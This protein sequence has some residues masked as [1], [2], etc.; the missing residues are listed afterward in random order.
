MFELLNTLIDIHRYVNNSS[1]FLYFFKLHI[2][3]SF[4][5]GE[6]KPFIPILKSDASPFAPI[7]SCTAT[8]MDIRVYILGW[9]S[10][11]YQVQVWQIYPS[12]AHICTDYDLY[13]TLLK[14][15]HSPVSLFLGYITMDH[16][17]LLIFEFSLV[18]IQTIVYFCHL[19][20]HLTEYY[21]FS[22][23]CFIVIRDEINNGVF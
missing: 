20:L 7:S 22:Y 6:C 3:C 21:Y 19:T 15:V 10:L 18:C 16:R 1:E 17:G 14:L 12:C 2:I 23:L 4:N 11:D 13:S 5:L 8:S 9:F